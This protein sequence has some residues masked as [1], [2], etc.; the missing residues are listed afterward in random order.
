MWEKNRTTTECDKNIV[1]CDV[2]TAQCEDNTI[3]CERK[4]KKEPP[5][6]TEI[7]SHVMLV[8]HNVRMVSSNVR[9]NKGT[10]MCDKNTY[11]FSVFKQHYIYFFTLFP[12]PQTKKK[13]K[14]K[15]VYF[16][17]F[18]HFFLFFFPYKKE[19]IFVFLVL[20][21]VNAYY[22]SKRLF[23]FSH[24]LISSHF[25]SLQISDISPS[26]SLTPCVP[27]SIFNGTRGTVTIW[28]ILR[29]DFV[30]SLKS[31]FFASHHILLLSI[32]SLNFLLIAYSYGSPD[33]W[34]SLLF[35][36]SP[37]YPWCFLKF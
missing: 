26:L 3:K 20:L 7:Q 9:K 4:K 13:K 22:Y 32:F 25:K 35:F 33:Q 17:L 29:S 28:S 23:S 36:H 16:F 18:T 5:N 21:K 12:L 1:T 11:M 10:T 34:R 8:L 31:F 24:V 6:V 27:F 30:L 15:N 14:K 37:I 19:P 2:G